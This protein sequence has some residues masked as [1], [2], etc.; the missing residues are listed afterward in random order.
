MQEG[1]EVDETGELA[2]V[3][4][5]GAAEAQPV[6]G[7]LVGEPGQVALVGEA[8]EL[9]VVEVVVEEAGALAAEHQMAAVDE[10]LVAVEELFCEK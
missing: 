3:V 6:V 7:V 1:L 5:V 9:A 4:V 8:V 2:V 10:A